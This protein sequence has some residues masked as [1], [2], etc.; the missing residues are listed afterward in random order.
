M[1]WSRATLKNIVKPLLFADDIAVP[2]TFVSQL[3][4]ALDL[5]S[6]WSILCKLRFAAHKRKLL[7][8]ARG[9]NDKRLLED[10]QRT[11]IVAFQGTNLDWVSKYPYLGFT[12]HETPGPRR[13][14]RQYTEINSKKARRL[15]WALR[16][17][18]HDTAR[19]SHVAPPALRLAVMQVTHAR[20]LYQTTLLDAD[21]NTL[22]T[23]VQQVLKAV[24]GLPTTTPSILVYVDLG[25]WPAEYHA[26]AGAVEFL[27]KLYWRY[28]TQPAFEVWFSDCPPPT[29]PA[30]VTTQWASGGVLA[31]FTTIL[32]R[33]GLTWHD[34]GRCRNKGEWKERVGDVSR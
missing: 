22:D 10:L 33:L 24:F 7:R 15:C 2:A 28:W 11:E 27:W 31:R 34:L 23:L 8:L 20:Y 32:T 18:F 12:I 3:R 1:P 25:L 13:H 6:R 19:C 4:T 29:V 14:H 16:R 17:T 21:Y 9:P 26:R 30:E 5:L